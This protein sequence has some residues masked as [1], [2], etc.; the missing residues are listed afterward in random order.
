MVINQPVGF[1][2]TIRN[3]GAGSSLVSSYSR[4]RID[5]G[6]NG[7]WDI[8]LTPDQV[9]AILAGTAP[10]PA[11]SETEVWSWTPVAGQEGN[12]YFEICA[13]TSNT[14]VNNNRVAESNELNNCTLPQPF[15]IA[16]A[17]AWLRTRNGDVGS[18]S[19]INFSYPNP[20]NCPGTPTHCN[21]SYVIQASSISESYFK[22]AKG[23]LVRNSPQ[24]GKF[25]NYQRL[26]R[27]FGDGNPC[28][29]TGANT[30]P[31]NKGEFLRRGN[32]DYTT[33]GTVSCTTTAVK[34][35]RLVFVEGDLTISRNV[36]NGLP[37]VFIVRGNITIR[38]TVTRVDA[39]LL[40]DRSISDT[41]GATNQLRVFGSVIGVLTDTVGDG[42]LLY[43]NVGNDCSIGVCNQNDP[44]EEIIFQPKY[45]YLLAEYLGVFVSTYREVNP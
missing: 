10:G 41:P 33:D 38:P 23:W 37:L 14:A 22:S 20:N 12:H 42:I 1:Q 25:D 4:L 29:L 2:G 16:L 45:L 31:S 24:L 17:S 13:D 34:D 9:S 19:A 21:S 27:Q 28:L 5:L 43:R 40:S 7:S 18:R 36:T 44:S 8:T 32:L 30:L 11:G 35:A 3:I 26:N 39:I 6:R 15:S